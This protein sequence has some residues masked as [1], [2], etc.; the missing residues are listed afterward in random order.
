MTYGEILMLRLNATTGGGVTGVFSIGGRNLGNIS[1]AIITY[2]TTAVRG[3]NPL[4]GGHTSPTPI[5]GIH[6]DFNWSLD[7][8]AGKGFLDSFGERHLK[9]GWGRGASNNNRGTWDVNH[10]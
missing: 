5:S 2:N 3:E 8:D 9:G 10:T 1:N 7:S 6:V 4:T